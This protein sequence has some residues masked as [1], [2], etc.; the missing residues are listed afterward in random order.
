MYQKR[1]KS[2]LEN[3]A[4]LYG[5]LTLYPSGVAHVSLNYQKSIDDFEVKFAIVDIEDSFTF[6]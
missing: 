2:T 4:G 6:T 5:V 1:P 3:S